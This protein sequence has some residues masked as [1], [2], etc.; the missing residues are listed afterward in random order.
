[1]EIKPMSFPSAAFPGAD[2]RIEPHTQYAFKCASC[3]EPLTVRFGWILGSGK[4]AVI[5]AELSGA[6]S[7]YLADNPHLRFGNH[8]DI[9]QCQACHAVYVVQ[10]NLNETSHGAFRVEISGV[11]QAA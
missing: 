10:S 6:I 8:L 4:Q 11:A 9:V 2:L 3:G 1:M 7:E 5:N